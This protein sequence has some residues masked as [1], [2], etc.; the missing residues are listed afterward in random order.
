M[1]PFIVNILETF[2]LSAEVTIIHSWGQQS[3]KDLVA[4]GN[5]KMTQW[6]GG[7]PLDPLIQ[8]NIFCS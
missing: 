2:Q 1:D 4:L 6:L 5:A 8:Q 3:S 7:L